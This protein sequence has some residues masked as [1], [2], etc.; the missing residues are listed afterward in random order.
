MAQQI[1]PQQPVRPQ[2]GPLPQVA[3]VRLNQMR[4]DSVHHGLFT[5][6]LSVNEFLLTRE[7]GFEPLGMVLGSSI[8]HIGWQVGNWNKNQEMGILTQA[9]YNARALAMARMVEEASMLGADGV[10]GVSIEITTQQWE[11][12]LAEFVAVGTAIRARNGKA[13][14]NALGQPF[15]SALSGQDFW[16]LLR[17][18]YLPAGMVLGNCVYH[19]AHQGMGQWFKQIGRNAEMVNYTQGLYEARELAMGRMQNES[20]A[21][22]ATGIVGVTVTQGSYEWESHVIEFFA[23]GNAVVPLSAEHTVPTPS[24]TLSLNN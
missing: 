15:T 24:L 12:E 21:L 2:P 14:R 20:L 22:Q 3:Q 23:L 5:S 7:A 13:Y 1:P 9:L 4:G 18:G 19:I 17:A 10:I 6:N 8:Y 11:T 16:T